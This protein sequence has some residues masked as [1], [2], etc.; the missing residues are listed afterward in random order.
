MFPI[1]LIGYRR[2]SNLEVLVELA[3]RAGVPRVYVALDGPL[4][5][6]AEPD[7]NMCLALIESYVKRYPDLILIKKSSKNLGLGV[8]VIT[9]CDWFFENEEFGAILEDDCIPSIDFF[10]WVSNSKVE[11]ENDENLLM[12]SGSQFY[13]SKNQI[14]KKYTANYPV[15]WGWAT[16]SDKWRPMSDFLHGG[17]FPS[18]A[19]SKMRFLDYIYWSSGTRRVFDGFIDT[20]DIPLAFFF[21]IHNSK[22][23]LPPVNLVSNI[24]FE[25]FSTHTK[26][27]SDH[28]VVPV[29]HYSK[30]M[31]LS[32]DSSDISSWYRNRIYGIRSRHLFTTQITRIC[33]SL[34][35][36]KPKRSNL[37]IRLDQYDS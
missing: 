25:S 20:W 5:K 11:L 33:D 17:I 13:Q 2:Y 23:L 37:R 36:N 8:S 24:G 9:A 1:L 31:Q 29:G 4:D 18:L 3:I 30:S 27:H 26:K 16:S 10:E 32:D 6:D 22:S 7:S 34:G 15:I 14:S 19:L 35:I 28:L 21:Q 12:V